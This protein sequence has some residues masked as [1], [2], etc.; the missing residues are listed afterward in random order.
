VAEVWVIL[1]RPRGRFWIG[2]M[3]MMIVGIG[4]LIAGNFMLAG[5]GYGDG[6]S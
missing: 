2:L 4:C 5:D 6:W 1:K 3:E